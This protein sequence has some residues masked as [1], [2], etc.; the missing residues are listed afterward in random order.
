MPGVPRPT[1]EKTRTHDRYSRTPAAM[2][3]AAY[4]ATGAGEAP[5]R[6]RISQGTYPPPAPGTTMVNARLR[7]ARLSRVIDA[8]G[9]GVAVQRAPLL[10]ASVLWV[11]AAYRTAA[12]AT[13]W[14]DDR[15]GHSLPVVTTLK[16]S[17]LSTLART[18]QIS[19]ILR[20]GRAGLGSVAGMASAAGMASRDASR[21]KIANIDFSRGS[22]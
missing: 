16:M 22:R 18:T 1:V 12:L 9:R 8:P 7:S 15:P 13:T 6:V 14:S 11:Q 20:T 5:W 3:A 19:T 4:Q 10:Q 2:T 21:L 17:A